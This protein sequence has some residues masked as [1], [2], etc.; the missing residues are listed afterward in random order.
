MNLSQ[1]VIL[2]FAQIISAIVPIIHNMTPIACVRVFAIS[3][4]GIAFTALSSKLTGLSSM[5]ECLKI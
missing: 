5:R 3:S 4:E 2:E 1:I